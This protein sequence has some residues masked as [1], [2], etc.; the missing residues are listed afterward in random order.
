MLLLGLELAAGLGIELGSELA[1]KVRS[2]ASHVFSPRSRSRTIKTYFDLIK[3]QLEFM[4]TLSNI[5][6]ISIVI[7]NANYLLQPDLYYPQFLAQ[8]LLLPS[9]ADNRGLTVV[10][11]YLTYTNYYSVFEDKRQELTELLIQAKLVIQA[12]LLNQGSN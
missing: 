3:I 9:T 7:S 11:S 1:A 8:K 12:E 10:I 4:L 6:I 2:K 5:F